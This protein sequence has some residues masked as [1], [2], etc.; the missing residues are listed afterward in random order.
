MKPEDFYSLSPGEA[1][2]VGKGQ[3]PIKVKTGPAPEKYWPSKWEKPKKS[4]PQP[5]SKTKRPITKKL[6]TTKVVAKN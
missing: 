5:Q 1:M 6:A 4:E 2:V 3:P